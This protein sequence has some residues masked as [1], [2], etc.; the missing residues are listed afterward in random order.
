VWFMFVCG[1]GVCFRLLG[2]GGGEG[3]LLVVWEGLL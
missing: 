3:F 2:V 1:L